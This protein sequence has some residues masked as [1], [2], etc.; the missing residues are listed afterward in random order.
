[1]GGMV[2]MDG[3]GFYTSLVVCAC[4]LC[5]RRAHAIVPCTHWLPGDR[6]DTRYSMRPLK[7]ENSFKI[8]ILM[9]ICIGL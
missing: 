1:M 8:Y 6:H 3:V 4:V 7:L 5:C 2:I 9:F